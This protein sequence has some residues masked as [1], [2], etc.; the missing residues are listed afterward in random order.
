MRLDV[1]ERLL[2]LVAV[3]EVGQSTIWAWTSMPASKSRSSTSMPRSAC[4]PMSLRRTSGEMAWSET[5]MGSRR[6]S[7]IRLTSSS[8]TFVSVTKFPC[9]NESLKSSSRRLSEARAS[10]G[11]MLMKQKMQP[12]TQVRTPSNRTSVNSMPQSSPASR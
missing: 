10:G 7:M 4:F 9:R 2:E 8:E 1:V 6:H 3:V 12:F 5:F 11:S